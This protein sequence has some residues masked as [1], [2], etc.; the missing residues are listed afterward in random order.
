MFK[1]LEITFIINLEDSSKSIISYE[2]DSGSSGTIAVSS[3]SARYLGPFQIISTS[4]LSMN[5]VCA[6]SFDLYWYYIEHLTADDSWQ[7][8]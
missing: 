4:A 3:N 7:G 1:F 5:S 6:T 8:N 2:N